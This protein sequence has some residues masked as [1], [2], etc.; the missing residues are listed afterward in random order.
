MLHLGFL[1]ASTLALLAASPTW[2][3]DAGDSTGDRAWAL[4]WS[5]EFSGKA[6]TQPSE[7]NWNYDIGNEEQS[8][9]GN[10]ELQYYTRSPENVR[11][12]G[13]G[14]LE[15]WARKNKADLWCWNGDACPYTSARL[16]TIGK[17]QVV[18][19]KIE[20]RIRVPP[21]QGYW[22]AFWTLGAGKPGNG[23]VP[24]PNNG[25][26]DIMEW[27]G[28]TPNTVYGTLHGPG[29]SGDRGLSAPVELPQPASAG[30][31]TFTLIKRKTEIIWLLD[32]KTYHRVTPKDLPSGSEWVFD[33]PFY[34][35][36][37][38]AVGGNWPGPPN[39]STVFPGA[40][41]VDYVRIWKE[42]Q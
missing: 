33:Q 10:K 40:M 32:G 19:G 4:V 35:L 12:D 24:W 3:Q 29:Y 5:D 36:L 26:L 20:A 17:V 15:L 38:L 27:L 1:L 21:G 16:T 22:P 2:A 37:N 7:R 25:E 6:G 31:H 42:G 23:K 11:L 30:F 39:A 8:G 13:K 34:L 41:K 28:R 9:W 14:N 18:Y